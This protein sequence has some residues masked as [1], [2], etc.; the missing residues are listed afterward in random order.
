MTTCTPE[1]C[2]PTS[3]TQM[4][5]IR[6]AITK[7][8]AACSNVLWNV[9]RWRS[10]STRSR[11]VQA[12]SR[13]VLAG[14]VVSGCPP[15]SRGGGRSQFQPTFSATR[16]KNRLPPLQP[17]APQAPDIPRVQPILAGGVRETA[18]HEIPRTDIGRERVDSAT[19]RCTI[20]K[21]AVPPPMA[22]YISLSANHQLDCFRFRN[23]SP[24][25]HPNMPQVAYS[26]AN[27]SPIPV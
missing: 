24:P 21:V 2:G 11:F 6:P 9:L 7:L 8:P 17:N 16:F 3:G 12:S 15:G 23:H 20:C 10:S 4:S 18:P 1:R 22:A 13:L 27:R 14:D 25:L 5:R 19:G 26:G